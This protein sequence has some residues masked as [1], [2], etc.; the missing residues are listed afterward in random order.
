MMQ[1]WL[2]LLGRRAGRVRRAVDWM[3]MTYRSIIA[4]FLEP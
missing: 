3:E 2:V 4:G 1:G